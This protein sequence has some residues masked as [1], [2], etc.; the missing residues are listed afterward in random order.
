[1][2]NKKLHQ[3]KNI[4]EAIHDNNLTQVKQFI[5]NGVYNKDSKQDPFLRCCESGKTIKRREVL[6][7]MQ[8]AQKLERENIVKYF[9]TL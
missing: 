1:M 5:K 9:Y 7:A 2:K 3:N 6:T 4:F 8:L